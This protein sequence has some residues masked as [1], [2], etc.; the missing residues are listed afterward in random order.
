MSAK[1][2]T[3][4]SSNDSVL[5]TTTWGARLALLTLI[6]LVVA[7]LCLAD[8][9]HKLSKDLDAL[10]ASHSGAT[11]DVIIQFNQTPTDA[12]HQKVQNKGGVLKTKLDF[13]K[14]AHYSVPVESLD[15]LAD[16]P[17]VAYISPDRRLNGSLDNTAAAVNAKVAWQSGWDGTGIGV[18]V[19]DSGITYH[20]D[21][22]GT[23]GSGG[24]LRVLYS[25]D[26]VGG[27]TN[28]YYGHGEHV[29]GIIAGNGKDSSYSTYARMF[30]GIAPNANLINLR[31]L[32]QNGQGTDSGV[33]SAI[34]VAI[35]LQG[36]Y[37]IRVMNLSLGRQVF[38]S[39]TQD[40]LCQA[41][42]AAW[43]KGIV[44]VAAAGNY[45]RDNSM[46]TEGY[47]TITSPGND[48]YVITVG[49]MKTQGSRLRSNSLIASYSSKGPTLL[50][51]VVKP[52][53]VAPGNRVVSLY[54][55][56]FVNPIPGGSYYVYEALPQEYPQNLVTYAYY[57]G[58]LNTWSTTNNYYTL[59]GTSMATPVVSGAAALLVQAQP[60]IT[61]DQ[62]KA[63]LMKTAYKAFP[64]SSTVVDPVTATTY[65]SEYDIF[66]VGA[67]YLD[68][69]AALASSD[70]ATGNALS[71]TAVYDSTQNAVYLVNAAG[72]TWDSSVLWGTSVVWGTNV[73]VNGTSVVW[74]GSVCWGTSTDAGFSVVWGTSVLWGTSNQVASETSNV[75]LGED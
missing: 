62:V 3:T 6:T 15:A 52:D 17:D 74:G 48:P 54:G 10:K 71:P 64:V 70:L 28:D 22:Y 29:A 47:A 61:P 9:K 38:E 58:S 45:G 44:V 46:G 31:V 73:F 27:G 41:V 5:K 51:H 12:H 30:K 7:G 66:T 32:D 72:S 57:D 18:A 50:D 69:G 56:P 24:K 59:S 20:S 33:I 8:G 43:K 4:R 16:D 25:Q 67:G 2:G 11:V 37:H 21:L 49:A 40:P 60:K 19:I 26:F 68:V 53:I 75:I 39:Y 1:L 13:I 23:T 42:E 36:K 63:R 34:Q 55:N 35:S 14:G 65:V